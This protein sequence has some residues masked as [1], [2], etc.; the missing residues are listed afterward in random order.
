MEKSIMGT[1]VP[2]FYT[3]KMTL[4]EK[5]TALIEQSLKERPDIFLMDLS[6]S[7]NNDIHLTLDGDNGVGIDDIVY[8][9]RQIEHN[10]DRDETDFSLTVTSVDI[11]KPFYLKR[12]YH[13]N[14]NRNLKVKT[15][16]GEKQGKL[17]QIDDDAIVLEYQVR[18]PKKTG[19]GKI[20]VTKQNRI[21]FDKIKEAKV[22]LKF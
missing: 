15:D 11:T 7:E 14:L 13:K 18:E 20:T 12:Q 17:I 3:V 10:L 19:K 6:I 9:S 1:V 22:V 4:K 16:E 2:Y 8:F 5:V 21:P